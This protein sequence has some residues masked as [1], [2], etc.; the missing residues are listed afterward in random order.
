MLCSALEHDCDDNLERIEVAACLFSSRVA[1]V[2]GG[3]VGDS[4]GDAVVDGD[5]GGLGLEGADMLDLE[6]IV[7]QKPWSERKLFGPGWE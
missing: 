6:L 7:V 2:Q 5:N 4:S 3:P 1:F